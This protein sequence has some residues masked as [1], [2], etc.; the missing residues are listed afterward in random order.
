MT[1]MLKDILAA[2][3]AARDAEK[4]AQAFKTEI[5]SQ[6]QAE[7]AQI[8]EKR[9]KQAEADIEQMRLEHKAKVDKA[10]AINEAAAENTKA[11]LIRCQQENSA[12]WV[13]EIYNRVIN[14]I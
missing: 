8:I 10:M 2:E 12:K 7:K 3:K 5:I 9:I 13:A 1:D 14:N 6:T 4:Q 11:A